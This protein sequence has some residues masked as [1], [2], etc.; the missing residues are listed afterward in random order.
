MSALELRHILNTAIYQ[1]KM[2]YAIYND[3]QTPWT[4]PPSVYTLWDG[5]LL[6]EFEFLVFA[7]FKVLQRIGMNYW[8]DHDSP[9]WSHIATVLLH[10]FF[11]SPLLVIS[12]KKNPLNISKVCK[13]IRFCFASIYVTCK[14]PDVKISPFLLVKTEIITQWK[15]L[16]IFTVLFWDW[17]LGIF[18]AKQ[19]CVCVCVCLDWNG[20]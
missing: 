2:V 1:H 15:K 18:A 17:I 3:H 14:N 19:P 4:H 13:V 16:W 6:N 7:V 10:F 20:L 8:T 5:F 11:T 12:L 9:A